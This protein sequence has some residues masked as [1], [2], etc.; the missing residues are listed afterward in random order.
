MT[1][2][3]EHAQLAA[4]FNVD[5]GTGAIRGVFLQRNEAVAPVFQAWMEPFRNIGMTTLS[6][7]NTLSTDHVAFDEVGLPAF[8]FIQDPMEYTTRTHHTN[9]DV[10]DRIQPSDLI[11]NAV[12]VA[13]FAYHAAN[14]DQKLPRKPLPRTST[15]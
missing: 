8:Q 4:Y 7:R 15:P 3:P 5:N 13:S 12:I 2:K 1:L 14:R 6:I 9:M 11:Q 10:Y